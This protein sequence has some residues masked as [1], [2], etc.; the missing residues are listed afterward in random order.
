MSYKLYDISLKQE[1]SLELKNCTI[2]G[3][4]TAYIVK[5]GT[6]T[7]YSIINGEIDNSTAKTVDRIELTNYQLALF[8]LLKGK[9]WKHRTI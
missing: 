2:T 3:N 8:D 5:D 9:R 1:S 7:K 4:S 6:I